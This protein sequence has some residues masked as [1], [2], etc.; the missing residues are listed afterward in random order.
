MY[1]K[2]LLFISFS[3]IYI[4]ACTPADKTLF[5]FN[6]EKL[7]ETEMTLLEIAEDISYI[8][9]DNSIPVNNIPPRMVDDAIYAWS[10]D[11]G[12]LVFNIEGKYAGKIGSIG[13]GPGEYLRYGDVGV[14]GKS[15]RVYVLDGKGIIKAFSESGRFIRSF[16]L[17]EYGDAIENIEFFNSV[18]FVKYCIQFDNADYEWIICD[19]LGNVIKKQNRHLPKFTANWGERCPIYKFEDRLSYYDPFADTV[20]S[21]LSDL[22]EIPLFTIANG[23]YRYPLSNL[24]VEQFLSRKYLNITNI[25]ETKR[26]FVIIYNHNKKRHLALIDKHNH[27]SFLIPDKYNDSG[28][29]C[30]GIKNDIDGGP[31]FFPESYFTEGGRDYLVGFQDPFQIKAWVESDE[32]RNL[33][34]KYPEKKKALVMLANN[35]KETDN[36]VI[37]MVLMKK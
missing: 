28:L 17:D 25:L 3:V 2:L 9:L 20:F 30:S 35:L 11:I 37:V 16:P 24:S 5:E 34:L 31:W 19:T 21:V 32:F 15:K 6:L 12:I 1:T 7:K 8:P 22:T 29:S 23:E 4:F 26:F 18:I 13:R 27:E 14:D 33:V 10:T 36:P